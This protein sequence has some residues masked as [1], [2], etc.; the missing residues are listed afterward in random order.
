MTT[1]ALAV[2]RWIDDSNAESLG[3]ASSDYP[4]GAWVLEDAKGEYRQDI[5]QVD[6][7]TALPLVEG[8]APAMTEQ[9]AE[10]AQR[11]A[12]D[13]I[14]PAEDFDPLHGAKWVALP[15][16]YGTAYELVRV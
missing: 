10:L 4:N 9:E 5:V 13:G 16:D 15:A 1:T 7:E 3:Y 11:L 12:L 14:D 8:M 6:E 2:L